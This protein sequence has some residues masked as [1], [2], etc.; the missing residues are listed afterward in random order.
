[1]L[2]ES[3]EPARRWRREAL[4]G[5]V[6]RSPRSEDVTLQE[7]E[8]EDSESPRKSPEPPGARAGD[9]GRSM[10]TQMAR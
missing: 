2:K 1:M 5:V 9:S 8:P 7:P 6:A 3:P 4:P 10:P